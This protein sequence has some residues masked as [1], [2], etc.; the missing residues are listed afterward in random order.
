MCSGFGG[1]ITKDGRLYFSEPDR[2]SD[3]SHSKT[4][5]RLKINE[6]FD[7][8]LR[9]FVR[10]EFPDWKP[11]SFKY[12]EVDTLPGWVDQDEIKDRASKLLIKVQ[13]ALAE[14]EKV[15]QPALAEYQKVNQPAWAEYQKVNQPALAEYEKVEQSALAE[16]EKAKQSAL[17]EYQKVNQPA[18]AEYEKVE[19]SALAEYQKVEQPAW[20]IMIACMAKIEGY[21]G[22]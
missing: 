18:L 6:N 2:D 12:D 3:C 20:A 7:Q 4:L 5:E 17:A 11:E 13:P 10:F 21:V 19:Q 8:F 15:E 22:E 16:Y 9:P 14:Y 1:I